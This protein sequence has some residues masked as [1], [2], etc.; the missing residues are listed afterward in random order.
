MSGSW[1]DPDDAPEWSDDDFAKATLVP[2]PIVTALSGTTVA[3]EWIRNGDFLV[4]TG[5]GARR[6]APTNSNR[7]WKHDGYA[8]HDAAPGKDL[9]Y[10][11]KEVGQ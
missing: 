8:A 2:A 7:P 10:Y 1:T 9:V 5:K 6:F 11:F 3:L 4:V